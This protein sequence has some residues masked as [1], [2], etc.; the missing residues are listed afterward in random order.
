MCD[1]TLQMATADLARVQEL[2]PGNYLAK[3]VQCT[4]Q[5]LQQTGKRSETVTFTNMFQPNSVLA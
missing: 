1:A 5:R 2:D 3:Q 4:L